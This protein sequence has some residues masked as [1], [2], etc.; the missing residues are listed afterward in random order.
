[1]GPVGSIARNVALNDEYMFTVDLLRADK[2]PWIIGKS[3]YSANIKYMSDSDEVYTTIGRNICVV[4]PTSII[5][6]VSGR[7][8]AG[9]GTNV[10]RYYG[11]FYEN[12][13][14]AIWRIE[15]YAYYDGLTGQQDPYG[16]IF[17]VDFEDLDNDD[18]K[19][20]AVVLHGGTE[21]NP[22]VVIFDNDGSWTRTDVYYSDY[23]SNFFYAI[24]VGDL[25]GD[26]DLDIATTRDDGKTYLITNRGAAEFSDT[27]EV[28]TTGNVEQHW[29]HAMAIA[30]LDGGYDSGPYMK[31]G[32]VVVATADGLK[33]VSFSGSSWTTTGIDDTIGW[34][35]VGLGDVDGDGDIDIVASTE[36]G[37]IY[38]FTQNGSGTLNFTKT[39]VKDYVSTALAEVGFGDIDG[40]GNL[41]IVVGKGQSLEAYTSS[42][43]LISENADFNQ[44]ALSGNIVSI[45]VGN[46]DGAI[47]DDVIVST[48]DGFVY[49]YRNLGKATE[50]L[51]FLV[52]DLGARLGDNPSFFSIA[53]GDANKGGA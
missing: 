2:D 10:P 13:G 33:R 6:V 34:T 9:Q 4:S 17:S 36:S 53:I 37:D 27:P 14:G 1:M 50:W 16:A 23:A 48:D 20:I 42:G 29:D 28:V 3:A 11:D 31:W 12:Q 47:Q 35:S 44:V 30:D 32:D 51:R 7:N 26:K 22:A 25:D 5:D 15:K 46:V 43:E 19:D 18:D 40:T 52:D 38:L 41:D 49:N 45:E 39:L 21:S 8:R 24:A